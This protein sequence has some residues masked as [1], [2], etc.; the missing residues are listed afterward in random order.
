MG[1]PDPIARFNECWSECMGDYPFLWGA[2]GLTPAGLLNLKIP[3]ERNFGKSPWTSLDR[4]FGKKPKG[5]AEVKRGTIGRTKNLGKAGS[6][7]T[8]VS[9]WAAGYLTGAALC[10][11]G[12]CME[13]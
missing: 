10:C 11:F 9:V 1:H 6:L 13:E 12:E 3:G 8:A 5:G 4:R 7:V 2:I